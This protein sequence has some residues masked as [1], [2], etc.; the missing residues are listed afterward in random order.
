MRVQA[1]GIWFK[2]IGGL[3]IVNIK[4]LM[5]SVGM[6]SQM[7]LLRNVYISLAGNWEGW[8]N[9][10]A[11]INFRLPSFIKIFLGYN[12]NYSFFLHVLWIQ[13]K[14]RRWA[15]SIPSHQ[16]FPLTISDLSIVIMID[17]S[18]SLIIY[19]SILLFLSRCCV[20][21]AFNN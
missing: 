9:I 11:R 13:Y 20:C 6:E 5:V 16:L 4:L 3:V 8:R 2:M 19:W 1:F 12:W 15:L 10:W 14:R 7:L 21:C 18:Y 17:R